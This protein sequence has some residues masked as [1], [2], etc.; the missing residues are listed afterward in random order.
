MYRE[1]AAGLCSSPFGGRLEQE[2][3]LATR[4][5]VEMEDLVR[6]ADIEEIQ[7]YSFRYDICWRENLTLSWLKLCVCSFTAPAANFDVFRGCRSQ[8][9]PTCAIQ[10]ATLRA[11]SPRTQ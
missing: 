7:K 6:E 1:E 10:A 2:G 11:E 5:V 8:A 4:K 3:A 9:L